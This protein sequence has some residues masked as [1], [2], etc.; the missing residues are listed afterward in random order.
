MN[1]KAAEFGMLWDN[2]INSLRERLLE[3]R[4]KKPLSYSICSLVLN[5]EKLS[6]GNDRS[7]CGKWMNTYRDSDPVNGDL[8][9]G[10]IMDNVKFHKPEEKNGFSLISFLREIVIPFVLAMAGFTLSTVLR[11]PVWVRFAATLIPEFAG[12]FVFGFLLPA[13]KSSVSEV[14]DYIS[15]IGKFKGVIADILNANQ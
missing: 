4:K 2:F 3:E 15:Q 1:N 14:D 12:F 11:A 7:E 5:D 9:F 8:I 6:W 10:I 13:P